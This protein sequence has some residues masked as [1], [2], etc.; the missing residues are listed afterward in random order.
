MI[1]VYVVFILKKH[2]LAITINQSN[3]TSLMLTEHGFLCGVKTYCDT[4]FSVIT[5][6]TG[7]IYQK[8]SLLNLY[9]M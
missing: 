3:R 7:K 2:F 5:G 6:I 4:K 1:T 9:I 8:K